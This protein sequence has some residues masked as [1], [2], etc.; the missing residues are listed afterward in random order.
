[1]PYLRGEVEITQLEKK[2]L[3]MFRSKGRC[4]DWYVLGKRKDEES[5]P[6]A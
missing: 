4:D 1:M 3:A 5:P 2:G 6:A